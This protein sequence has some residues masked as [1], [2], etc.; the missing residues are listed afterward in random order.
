MPLLF[1]NKLNIFFR[2]FATFG[3]Y[4][5]TLGVGKLSGDITVNMVLMGIGEMMAL[6]AVWL[7]S[8]W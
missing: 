7:L 6:V 1:H 4:A 2:F 8:K 3:Y 5:L